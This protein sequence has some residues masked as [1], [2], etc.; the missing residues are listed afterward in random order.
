[1]KTWV[2]NHVRPFASTYFDGLSK[3]NRQANI[4]K[5]D[6]LKRIKNLSETGFFEI[7]FNIQLANRQVLHLQIVI[8]YYKILVQKY[9]RNMGSIW[10]L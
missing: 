2:I 1:M 10:V 6:K 7:P 5:I 4:I 8:G 3:N 9:Y